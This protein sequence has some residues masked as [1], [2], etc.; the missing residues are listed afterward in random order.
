MAK[1]TLLKLE[2]VG[3][4]GALEDRGFE[5]VAC[6]L[7]RMIQLASQGL[8]PVRVVPMTAAE[9]DAFAADRTERLVAAILA[10]A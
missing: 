9:V 8:A 5:N 4:T 2:Y 3:S 10:V 1:K 7:P 6:A